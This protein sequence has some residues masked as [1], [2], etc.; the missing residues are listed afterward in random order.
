MPVAG[1]IREVHTYP[2]G[3]CPKVKVITRLEFELTY[4][5]SVVHR[6]NHYTT[7]TLLLIYSFYGLRGA[8]VKALDC[9][10]VVS[11]FVLPSRYYVHFQANTLGR[12]M[13]PLI[14]PAMG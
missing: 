10:V 12:G 5:D 14:H 1:R 6:F 3:I 11:E 13:N 9:G 4:Y 8:M 2:T 7:R